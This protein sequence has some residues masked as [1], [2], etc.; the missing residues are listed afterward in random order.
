MVWWREGLIR[1]PKKFGVAA[2]TPE[3]A[4]PLAG[5]GEGREGRETER[6]KRA[7]SR[8]REGRKV[9]TGPPIG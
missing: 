1:P 2:L 3:L 4:R 9:G 6:E 5:R 8:K 7:E